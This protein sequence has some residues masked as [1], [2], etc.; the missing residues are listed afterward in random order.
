MVCRVGG[1]GRHVGLK[2]QWPVMAV[3]VR[4]LYPVQNINLKNYNIME[5]TNIN[6]FIVYSGYKTTS[7]KN[8]KRIINYNREMFIGNNY[9]I[10]KRSMFSIIIEWRAHNLLYNL[11]IC[12]S[13]TKD[14]DIEYPIK[15]YKVVG[16][17]ILSLLYPHI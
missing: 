9:S 10:N 1:I 8:M 6:T 15:W 14:V 12:R 3:Q 16:Y 11:H 17:F 2:I 4:F 7:I 5:K 13:R